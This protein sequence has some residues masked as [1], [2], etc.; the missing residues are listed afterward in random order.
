VRCGAGL[1]SHERANSWNPSIAATEPGVDIQ[2]V[3]VDSVGHPIHE[4]GVEWKLKIYG[5]EVWGWSSCD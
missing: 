1:S 2:E 3:H 5:G 4:M